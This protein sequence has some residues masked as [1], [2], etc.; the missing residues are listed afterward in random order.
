MSVATNDLERLKRLYMAGFANPYLDN[1]LRKIVDHQI[2]R[3]EADLQRVNRE[4]AEF[5]KQ[6]GLSSEEFW[7]RF[8]AGRMDDSADF[9]EWNAFCKM[10]QRIWDRLAILRGEHA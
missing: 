7:S 6:Y 1:A 3:D 5:E 8:K 2:A 4:L 10:R 9:M